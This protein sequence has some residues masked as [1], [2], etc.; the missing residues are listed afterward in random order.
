MAAPKKM[1]KDAPARRPTS[2]KAWKVKPGEL[3]VPSGNVCLVRRPG[4]QAFVAQG[5]IPN[6]LM[7]TVMQAAS[8]KG[9][10]DKT[11]TKELADI[12]S[13]PK[14]LQDM[15][16]MV[17]AVAI[18]CVVEPAIRPAEWTQEDVAD[19][20]CSA[21]EVGRKIPETRRDP[22]ELHVDEVDEEDKMFIFNWAVGGDRDVDRFR[23]EQ[24]EL[25]ES[26]LA[27]EDVGDHA[28]PALGA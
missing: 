16:G 22:D 9:I 2:A 24:G 11:M 4:I 25:L 26:V 28:E 17:D 10:D 3:E 6:S 23:R 21:E 19:G 15:L 14:K 5:M 12:A 27:G 20:R 1:K 13:N 7:S 8:G 18:Y